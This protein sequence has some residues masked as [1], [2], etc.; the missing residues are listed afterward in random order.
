M[1]QAY[2]LGKLAFVSDLARLLIIYEQG[3]GYFDTDIGLLSVSI[4]I[5]D[6]YFE[7]LCVFI[8]VLV[9]TY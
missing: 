6:T 8:L 4:I 7:I 2:A 5:L 3:G 1:K 9:V